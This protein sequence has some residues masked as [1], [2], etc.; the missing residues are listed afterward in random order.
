MSRCAKCG[1]PGGIPCDECEPRLDPLAQVIAPPRMIRPPTPPPLPPINYK[2]DRCNETTDGIL[3]RCYECE[4]IVGRCCVG[5]VH[6]NDNMC[7]C[8]GCFS[9]ICDICNADIPRL[10]NGEIY[11]RDRYPYS[12]CRKCEIDIVEDGMRMRH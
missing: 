12:I 2:C 11:Y 4:F 6:Y 9:F 3:R 7:S 10:T 5:V 1:A 8:D